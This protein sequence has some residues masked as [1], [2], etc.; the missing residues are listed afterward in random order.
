MNQLEHSIIYP[1]DT[2]PFRDGLVAF[3]E[4]EGY[5]MKD[6]FHLT[7]A[8]P[9]Y[10]Q[11]LS[12][13][14]LEHFEEVLQARPL[15]LAYEDVLYVVEKSKDFPSQSFE[16]RSIIALLKPTRLLESVGKIAT[17][18][19]VAT[20]EFF[21]HVTIATAPDNAYARRGIG[22]ASVVEW[23]AL[24]PEIYFEGWMESA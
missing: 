6:E 9:A 10:R 14:Q 24:E 18:L 8:N 5:R 2:P 4:D 22:I 3:M 16:R 23:I 12:P 21:P 1:V 17:E 15:P 13:E 7:I 20:P 19:E 11:M